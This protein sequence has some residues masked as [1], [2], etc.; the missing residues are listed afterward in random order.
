MLTTASEKRSSILPTSPLKENLTSDSTKFLRVF[1]RASPRLA[2]VGGRNDIGIST[3][4]KFNGIP[5]NSNVVSDN[6]RWYKIE[7]EDDNEEELTHREITKFVQ[8]A[9]KI[10]LKKLA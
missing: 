3:I 7:Y 1:G 2:T 9:K 4:K 5:Y 6:G 8:Q 10:S